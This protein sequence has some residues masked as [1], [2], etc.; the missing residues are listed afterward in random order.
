VWKSPVLNLIGIGSY[1][2][3]AIVVP[4]L[5]GQYLDGRFGTEPVLTLVL[6]VVGLLAGFLGAY[7]QLQDVLREANRE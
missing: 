1:L 6:L 5:F 7:R 2:A 4:T 3:T